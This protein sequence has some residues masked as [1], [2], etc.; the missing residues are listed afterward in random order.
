M[1]T[2]IVS[3]RVA[4]QRT[5][6]PTSRAAQ[7]RLALLRVVIGLLAEAAADIGRHHPDRLLGRAQ[8]VARKPLADEMRVLG[9]GPERVA[10]LAPV[11]FADGRARLDRARRETVVGELER[12]DVGR[13]GEGGLR[14]SCIADA[15]VVGD[16][17]AELR[18]HERRPRLDRRGEVGD[19]GERLPRDLDRS[20]GVRRGVRVFGDD[21][22]YRIAHM[23]GL[24][25]GEYGPGSG[26]HRGAVMGGDV[27]QHVGVATPVVAPVRAGQHGQ[28]P[29]H[30]AR[31][32][33]VDCTE[34]GAG[35]G[36]ADEG[37]VRLPRQADVV[38][39]AAPA[40]QEA[41]VLQSRQRRA[42]MRHGR[43]PSPAAVLSAIAVKG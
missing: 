15:P 40:G 8:R 23:A 2:V 9:R 38:H 6:R 1:S 3:A 27:P 19:C 25:V 41:V 37:G 31:P 4:V 13:G 18:V 39:E 10:A 36:A 17:A 16:V 42:D 12:R 11:V 26:R 29:R 35:M 34:A 43:A 7:G 20:C 30:G 32:V 5:G 28:H 22:G 33:G 21:E 14:R 24:A